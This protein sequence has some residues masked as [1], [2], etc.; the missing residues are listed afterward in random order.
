LVF[1][2]GIVFGLPRPEPAFGFVSIDPAQPGK[3]ALA[4]V[5]LIDRCGRRLEFVFFQ[6]V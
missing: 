2:S 1:V 6:P 5:L 4:L 3:D